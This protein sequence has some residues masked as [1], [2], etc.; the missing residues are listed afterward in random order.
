MS[1]VASLAIVNSEFEFGN[2]IGVLET[3]GTKQ[4]NI[5]I[6]NTSRV[7]L[8]MKNTPICSHFYDSVPQ[9]WVLDCVCHHCSVIYYHHT[10]FTNVMN[11]NLL[12]ADI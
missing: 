7:L 12:E 10:T 9:V 11:C 4:C 3:N 2:P 1:T 5:N 6:K 8:R